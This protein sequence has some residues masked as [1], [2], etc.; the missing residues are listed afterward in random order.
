MY[1]YYFVSMHTDN[2]WWKSGLTMCQIIQF[3]LMN[4]QAIYLLATGCQ[5]YPVKTIYAYFAYVAS[6]LVLFGNFYIQS[7]LAGNNDKNKNNSDSKESKRKEKK[8]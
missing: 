2:I 3:M 4:S 6:L 8:T 7:Y 1:T 5:T